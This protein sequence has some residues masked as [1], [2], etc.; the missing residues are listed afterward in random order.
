VGIIVGL[1]RLRH[2]WEQKKILVR[3]DEFK[4]RVIAF[5]Q[6]VEAVKERHKLL[7]A[8]NKEYRE[9]MTGATLALYQQVE[10]DVQRLGDVWLERMDLWEQVQGLIRSEKPFGAGR[11]LQAGR[12]LDKLGAFE[13]VDRACQ[14]CA[15]Q[16]DRVEKGHETARA[17]VAKAEE[18]T[19]ILRQRLESLRGL[20]LATAPYEPDLQAGGALIEQGRQIV[21]ADPIGASATLTEA[22]EKLDALSARMEAVVRLFERAKKAPDELERVARLTAARRGAGL[23]LTEP[24]GDPDPLLVQGRAEHAEALEALQRGDPEAGAKHLDQAFARAEQA[25]QVIERQEAARARCGKEIPARRADA[26]RLRREADEAGAQ[27]HQLEGGFAPESWCEVADNVA[28]AHELWASAEGL[29]AEAE[30][31]SAESRQHYFR[32]AGLLDQVQQQQEEAHGLLHAVGRCLQGLSDVRQECFPRRQ[33]VSDLAHKAQ[34]FL[35][36]HPRAVR[37]PAR[38]RLDAAEESWRQARAEMDTARPH[39]P[40]ARQRLDEARDGY[41]AALREAEEDVR[42]HDRLTARLGE[43]GREAE[44]VG[45]FLQRSPEARAQANQ[46]LRSATDILQRAGHESAGRAADWG[47]LL[48]QVEEAAN[49]LR[50]AEQLAQEDVRLAERSAAEIAEA[51]RELDRARGSSH[52]GMMADLGRA[53][54]LLS[55]ARLHLDGDAYEQAVEQAAAARQAARQAHDEAVRQAQQRQEEERR[56]REAEAAA[57]AALTAAPLPADP[58]PPPASNLAD[59]PDAPVAPDEPPPPL[60]PE[61]SSPAQG[62]SDATQA[63]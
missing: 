27:R 46:A 33:D 57:A 34:G 43:V 26:E 9:S 1:A 41:T 22:Q 6:K 2:S 49:G 13:E 58:S 56:R 51:E 32:A 16:L 37:Q 35:A 47:Q 19:G 14:A 61:E 17:Q 44:R 54:N 4:E 30:S 12:L 28:R 36:A 23:R 39:W 42:A 53:T 31:A 3:F 21:S 7:P 20:G 38:A 55:Q 45:H 52:L 63:D 15:T 5:R 60:T 8:G 29:L 40:H 48:R 62:G 24:E 50:K 10:K 11:F 18:T 59:W 25:E